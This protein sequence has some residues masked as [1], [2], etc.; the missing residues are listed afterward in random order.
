MP[1]QLFVPGQECSTGGISIWAP[2]GRQVY[3]GMLLKVNKRFSKHFQFL[4][5]YALQNENSDYY[6][7][8]LNNYMESYGPTLARHNINVSGLVTFRYGIELSV[9]SSIISRTPVQ[10]LVSGIDLSG[11]GATSNGP[12]PHS[13]IYDCFGISC[14]KSTLTQ[15][16]ASW[17]ATYA[18]TRAPNGAPIPAL[19]VPPDYQFGDPTFAQ[20]FRLTKTFTYKEKYRLSIFGEAFNAFNIANLTG[21]SSLLDTRSA[22][23]SQQTYSFGQ[24]TQRS[25]QSFLSGGPRA[26]QFGA[27]F[28]F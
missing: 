6:V 10:P 7:Q 4:A 26:L 12:L 24:P 11:T 19:A 13:G 5:S 27:R 17:N 28:I 21:Y 9:N 3:E 25:P 22:V 14:G 2:Y 23:P 8:N 18:G 16:V 1:S 20:D 15:A